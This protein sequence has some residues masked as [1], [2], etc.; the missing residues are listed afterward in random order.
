[1]INYVTVELFIGT[2][3]AISKVINDLVEYCY[4]FAKHSLIQFS[5]RL[6]VDTH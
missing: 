2:G 5:W 4:I 6:S 3:C 1:V